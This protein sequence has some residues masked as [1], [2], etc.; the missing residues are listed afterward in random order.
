MDLAD[1]TLFSFVGGGYLNRKSVLGRTASGVSSQR[2]GSG[3]GAGATRP[4]PLSLIMASRQGLLKGALSVCPCTQGSPEPRLSGQ[5]FT[6]PPRVTDARV[7]QT[8]LE[9]V[10]TISPVARP[11]CFQGG[12]TQ[13]RRCRWAGREGPVLLYLTL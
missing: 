7:Q 12:R 5:V 4:L 1:P 9:N 6:V 2:R 11:V 3:V 13:G 8:A 10:R